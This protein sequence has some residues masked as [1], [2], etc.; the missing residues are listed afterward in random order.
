MGKYQIAGV[1]AG[2]LWSVIVVGCL[3][4]AFGENPKALAAALATVIVWKFA[5]EG[6]R[7]GAEKAHA[8]EPQP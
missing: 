7:I 2:I 1:F 3:F 6:Y 4:A 5:S 8:K